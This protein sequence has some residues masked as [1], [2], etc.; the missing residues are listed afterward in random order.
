MKKH[1]HLI[2]AIVLATCLLL[3][4]VWTYRHRQTLKPDLIWKSTRVT[5]QTKIKKLNY[6]GLKVSTTSAVFNLKTQTAIKQRLAQ[7]KKAKTYTLA[8]PLLV[9]N[10]YKTNTTGLYIYFKTSLP[11]KLTYR[12]RAK[13]YEDYTGTLYSKNSYQKIHENQLIGAIAGVKNK[14]TLTTTDKSG[15]Q[16]STTFEYTAPKLAKTDYN[17]YRLVYG[18]SS[19]KPSQG[20]F[21]MIGDKASKT[22]RSTYLIDNSGAIRAEFPIVSYNS[23][24]L[25]FRQHHMY[26]AISS[27]EIAVMNHLGQITKLINTKQQGYELHHDYIIQG[28]HLWALATSHKAETKAKRVEDQIIKINI[29]TGKITKVIDLKQVLPQLYREAKGLEKHSA[30]RGLHDPVHLN[31]I[32]ASSDSLIVSSRETSTI[33]KLGNVSGKVR[34]DYFISDK[35]VWQGVGNYSKYLLKQKGSFL[36]SAGQHT[37]MIEHSS[38]L[39]SGQYY[40]YMFNNNYAMMDSR[41]NFNWSAYT[42]MDKHNNTVKGNYSLYYKYLVDE[43]QRTYKLVKAF[44]VPKSNYVSSAQNYHGNIIIDSGLGGIFSKYDKSGQVIRSYYYRGS[45]RQTYRTIKYK[46]QNFF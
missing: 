37:V 45:N 8:S 44:R 36:N 9:A 35:S 13:G 4:G 34:I 39:K 18:S 46:L 11:T 6:Q 12:V 38:S 26:Y 40:L 41:P 30:N 7:L 20:L 5:N 15:N 24:R 29:K 19:Q 43:K 32:Q 1:R 3:T 42:E 31:T 16:H 2:I 25:N 21:A 27:G 14:I 28:N 22:R 17:S 23:M 10:P 33:M